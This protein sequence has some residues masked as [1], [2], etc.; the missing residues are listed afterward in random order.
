LLILSIV[1]SIRMGDFMK[2]IA[3]N[4]EVNEIMRILR[5]W[6]NM[7]QT[8]FGKAMGK[9]EVAIRKYEA[10][11]IFCNFD[12]ILKLCKENGIKI[13]FEKK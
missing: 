12:E 1:T 6:T 8:E 3:N 10:G 2:M 9:S 5:E 4:Y 13:T 7:T 11:E